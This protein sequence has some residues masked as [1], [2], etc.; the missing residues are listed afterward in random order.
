MEL[1]ATVT[2][3]GKQVKATKAYQSMNLVRRKIVCKWHNIKA[4]DNGYKISLHLGYEKW[5]K[6]T[7]SDYINKGIIKELYDNHKQD[8]V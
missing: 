6:E 3:T 2:I 4:I 7:T 1:S 5:E 8:N